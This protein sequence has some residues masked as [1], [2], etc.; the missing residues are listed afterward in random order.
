[1][2]FVIG[3]PGDLAP[4]RVEARQHDG[5]G[6]VVDDQVDA[7]RLLE[8][9]DVAALAADDPA[10]HLVAGQVDDRD[11]VLG[12]V[13]GG[14]ALHR[15]DDDLARLLLGLVA[16]PSLD[17]AGELHGVVL[18]LFADG[19]EEDALGILGGHAGDLLEGGHALLV[20]LREVLA[21]VLEIA[22]AVVDLAALLLEHV[23]ALVELLVAGEQAA[24]EVLELGPALARL[25]LGLALLAQLL[26][27][28]LE[29]HV[30]LLGASLGDDPGG[31]VL[32]G[33]DGLARNDAADDES[34]GNADDRGDHRRDQDDRFHLQF[35]PSGRNCAPERVVVIQASGRRGAG[36]R[37][38]SGAGRSVGSSRSH[39]VLRLAR[40]RPRRSASG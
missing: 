17:R 29:D 39:P 19:L 20:E 21:L 18:R 28:R 26:V 40:R 30:L 15:R 35:L 4:N 12:G 23:G 32:G 22:L 16:G 11:G 31:L 8:R 34:H 7:G 14:H 24:L 25:L 33:L 6:R 27:L 1:M 13:V 38:G 3:D 10:L 2:S 5:L 36:I 9:P 37:V